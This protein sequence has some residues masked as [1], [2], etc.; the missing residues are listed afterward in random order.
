MTGPTKLPHIYD[1]LFATVSSSSDQNVNNVVL[2]KASVIAKM[3]V[4]VI[5]N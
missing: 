4:P 5:M 3:S 2:K 1:S